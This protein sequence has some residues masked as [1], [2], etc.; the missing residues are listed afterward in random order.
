[1]KGDVEYLFH[2]LKNTGKG[3]SKY[4][5]EMYGYVSDECSC[6]AFSSISTPTGFFFFLFNVQIVKQQIEE[7]T[8]LS[9]QDPSLWK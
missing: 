6:T 3:K 7:K 9:I 2:E 8:A 4:A 1:M 5:N